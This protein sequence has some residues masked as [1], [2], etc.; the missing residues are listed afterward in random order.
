[1]ISDID[2]VAEIEID[3]LLCDANGVAA[4][5]AD[6]RVIAAMRRRG[7]RRLAIR[8]YPREMEETLPWNDRSILVR[9]IRPEDE[10]ALAALL[11][12]L[13]PVDLRYRFFSPLRQVPRS[14]LARFTQI[15]YDREMSLVVLAGEPG[16]T[17]NMLGEARIVGNVDRE[18]AEFAIVVRSDMAGRG[19]GHILL[20]RLVDIS[21]R[22][23]YREIRGETMPEN[24]RMRALARALG[25]LEVTDGD[26]R[27]VHLRLPLTAAA[28]ASP[29]GA[30]ASPRPAARRRG[31]ER[32]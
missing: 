17:E 13:D 31:G 19:L 30:E 12:A 7:A 9:P 6:I 2:E 21:R 3:P 10:A 32:S 23:G 1:L 20:S 24:A 16:G 5:D 26:P 4:A 15:D 28:G 14:Q 8:P 11:E 27:L 29:V 18:W 22:E 25:F